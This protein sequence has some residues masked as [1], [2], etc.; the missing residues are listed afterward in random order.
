MSATFIINQKHC[1]R[2][3]QQTYGH[4]G[5]KVGGGWWWN[6]LGDWDGRIY[7]NMYKIDN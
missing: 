2:C 4:Q 1:F 3:R 5:G 7:T 6:K